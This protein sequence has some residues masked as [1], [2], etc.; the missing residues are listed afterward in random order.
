MTSPYAALQ[1]R[2]ISAVDA[3]LGER[4]W[5]YPLLDGR[6]DGTREAGEVCGVVRIQEAED[7]S[8]EGGRSGSWGGRV[9]R[10]PAA[11]H[12]SHSHPRAGMMRQHDKV[13]LLD[14]PGEPIFEILRLSTDRYGRLIAYL[15][16]T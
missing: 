6:A 7:R 15:G 13:R 16:A 11:A 4:I 10:S 14:R 9:S 2:A 8:L 12:I 1:R 3:A 5:H